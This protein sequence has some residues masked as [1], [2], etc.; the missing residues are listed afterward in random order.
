MIALTPKARF[1]R[2]RHAKPHSD[3]VLSDGIQEALASALLQMQYNEGTPADPTIAAAS[4]HRLAGAR[5][6][7]A[8]FLNLAE[9]ESKPAIVPRQNLNPNV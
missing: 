3:L 8:V 7:V 1:Q 5:A 2:T 6:F 9:P 4:W